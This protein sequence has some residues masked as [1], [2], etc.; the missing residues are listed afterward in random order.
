MFD[1][2]VNPGFGQRDLQKQVDAEV[3]QAVREL[4]ARLRENESREL[5]AILM[6]E[7]VEE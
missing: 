7:S 6:L 1:F 4:E 3:L 5:V 2:G